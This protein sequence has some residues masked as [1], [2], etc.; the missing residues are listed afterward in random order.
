VLNVP[1]CLQ[2]E[3]PGPGARLVVP[4]ATHPDIFLWSLPSKRLDRWTCTGW[5]SWV[6]APSHR[7]R[8][9]FGRNKSS[10]E[11]VVRA[12][13]VSLLRGRPITKDIDQ[14]FL[15]LAKSP[16]RRRFRLRA[17]ELRYLERKGLNAV[18]ADAADLVSKRLGAA[19]PR[20]D[21]KQTP[22]R[23]HPA[24][25]AQHATATCCRGCLAKWH[26]IGKGQAL[27]PAEL[28]HVTAVIERWLRRQSA[29]IPETPAQGR[30]L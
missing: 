9:A 29:G 25:I 11:I 1:A 17:E 6:G 7:Q 14:L 19:N 30:L 5:V 21:G 24:F 13:T 27:R 2:T 20:N 10:H 18:L 3:K 8:G 23:G 22:M 28:K 15:D 16:F 4:R 26:G 12:S